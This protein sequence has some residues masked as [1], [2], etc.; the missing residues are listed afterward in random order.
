M[1]LKTLPCLDSSRTF[2]VN[3]FRGE[4]RRSRCALLAVLLLIVAITWNAP[5]A[6]AQAVNFGRINVCPS[7]TTTPA[8]CSKTLPLTFNIPA[9]T[10]IGSIG[11]LTFGDQ[12]LDFKAKANDTSTTLC[13]AKTYSSATTCTVDVT[14]APL[15]PGQRKGAV[16]IVDGSGNLLANAYIDGTGVAPA[17]AFTPATQIA[18]GSGFYAS[19][20]AVDGNG[21]VFVADSGRALVQEILAV[22]GSIPAN[23]TILTLL[24]TC[25]TLLP[26]NLAIDGSGNLVFN[27][28]ETLQ[29]LLAV[30][31]SIPANPTLLN[32]ASVFVNTGYVAFDGSGN[33]YVTDSNG[34]EEGLAGNGSIPA[35]P[36]ILTLVSGLGGTVAVDGAGNVFVGDTGNNAVKEILAVNGSIPAN[37][38][39]LTL[40]SGLSGNVAVDA[41]GDV[42]VSGSGI[43]EILAVNGSIP[44]NPTIDIL[45]DIPTGSGLAMDGKGNVFVSGFSGVN[46][47]GVGEL[48][49]SQSPTLSF[50]PTGVGSTSSD[51][52]LSTKIQNVGNATLSLTELSVSG[53]G[54]FSMVPGSGTPADCTASSSLAPGAE[55][56]L[57]FSFKPEAEGPLTG[58]VTLKDNSMNGNPTHTISLL[59]TGI[60]PAP[61]QAQVSA[62]SLQFATI[63]FGATETLP[64]TV[65]NI[66][67]LILTIAPTING[68]S[69]NIASSNCAAGLT[70][71]NSC[72]LQVEF[73]P[74][75]IGGSD[76]ILTLNANGLSNPTVA[77]HGIASGVT[78]TET[79]LEFGTIEVGHPETL[80]LTIN[81]IAVPGTLTFKFP[82]YEGNT[83]LFESAYKILTTS[84]NTC[85]KGVTAGHSCT[86]PVEFDPVAAGNW[87]DS[88]V[89]HPNFYGYSAPFTVP[90]NGAAFGVGTEGTPADFGSVNVCPSG[91]TIPAPCSKTL[92]LTFNVP[93]GTTIGS[94]SYLTLGAQN[95]DFK[96][97]ANDTSTTLCSAQTYSSATTC[98]VDVTFAPVAPGARNGAVEILDGSGNILANAYIYGTGVG[99]AIAFDPVTP[100]ALGSGL[101]GS[102]VV[103]LDGSGD[104][105]VGGG[106]TVQEI[107][108]AGGYTTIKTLT[109]FNGVYGGAVAV[110]GSG[111]VF[112]A[113]GG[114]VKEILA[115]NGNIPA[116]PTINTLASVPGTPHG[117]AVD[118]SGNVF[119][120]NKSFVYEILAAGGYTTIRTVWTETDSDPGGVAVDASGNV[121]VALGSELVEILAVN[122]SIPANPAFDILPDSSIPQ[123][124]AAVDGSGNVF[125]ANG[126]SSVSEL[127]RSQPPS[128]SFL[129][130]AVGSTSSDS[131]QSVQ[132]QNV[133]NATLSLS[134]LSVSGNFALVPGSGTRPTAPPV[135]L[136]SPGRSVTSASASRPRRKGRWPAQSRCQITL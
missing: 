84:Q 117:I 103:A 29:E 21:N 53:N 57:S 20:V 34:V 101:G 78:V 127:P 86:L 100:I 11:Y 9:G 25:C 99:P 47:S 75:A 98:T 38:T 70:P 115:L 18:L 51:S 68:P 55:C 2:P 125:A 69:Y 74:V 111:N 107:L 41:A 109:S 136:F 76:G 128:V 28:E 8:P 116:N 4:L 77:L 14:F 5:A 36:T 49:R 131:P 65:T 26:D 88:L 7:G 80:L 130:A 31:G 132:I 10:T 83:L 50:G 54:N 60:N 89:V 30:N 56:N 121:L 106:R 48:A 39:I 104:V 92:P 45:L 95:L 59:G 72:T 81:D 120:S 110:D 102:E 6:G 40:A 19:G 1:E 108:A 24:N 94:I 22:N 63:P 73:A 52:P 105:I 135:L 91:A 129:P 79:T 23:P 85:Q 113:E 27:N 134:E 3:P 87:D 66:G 44:A 97:K 62:T 126:S 96:A 119:Y 16:Q 15:A 114:D 133:G 61:P 37:P 67:G 33:L 118:A 58:T 112:V 42:Y 122:G 32:W 12:N 13:S 64:L 71:G 35:N 123:P 43:S 90:L 82:I 46:P 17:I 124:G 93:A